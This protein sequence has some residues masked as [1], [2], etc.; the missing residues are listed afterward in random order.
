MKVTLNA[1]VD[2][3]RELS[4]SRENFIGGEIER[5]RKVTS[6][7]EEEIT[8]LDNKRADILSFLRSREAITDLTEAFSALSTKKTELSDLSGKL[9]TYN[10]LEK[11]KID[12]EA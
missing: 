8:A 3:R 7:R 6:E 1:A 11:E 9:R 5:L 4:K 2:F 10:T 12:I